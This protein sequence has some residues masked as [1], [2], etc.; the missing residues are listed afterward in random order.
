MLLLD[1]GTPAQRVAAVGGPR[2]ALRTICFAPQAPITL[3]L[4]SVHTSLPGGLLWTTASMATILPAQRP[5]RANRTLPRLPRHPSAS[6]G[7]RSALPSI[8]S[9]HSILRGRRLVR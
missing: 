4:T 3:L 8:M 9:R 5:V 1:G 7:S 2:T 6:M